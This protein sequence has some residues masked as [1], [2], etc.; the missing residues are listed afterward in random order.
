M[1]VYYQSPLGF[2]KITGTASAVTEVSFVDKPGNNAENPS[3]IVKKCL[4]E[5]DQYFKGELRVFTVPIEQLGTVFQKKVWNE[6]KTIPYGE[7]VS[8]IH[9][10]REIGDPLSVRAVG[11]TNGKNAIAIII[12]CHR[13]IG[14]NGKLVGYAGELWRKK[15]LLEHERNRRLGIMSLL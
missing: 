10:A 7:T 14:A 2:I 11:T 3:E 5:L 8:Y 12:P 1:T 9:I 15:W 6:L 13:V 4:F